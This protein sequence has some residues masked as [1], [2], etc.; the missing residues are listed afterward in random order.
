MA[1]TLVV[2]DD[3]IQLQDCTL[4]AHHCA[5]L[6]NHHVVPKS[7][8]LAAGVQVDSPMKLLCPNCHYDTHAAI[9][10]LIQGRDVSLLPPRCVKLARTALTL[11]AENN[12]TPALT[13]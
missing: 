4:Y 2:A 6:N 8:W 12:L 13:L 1:N 9:D 5:V 3:V 7:W 10:G 11:A